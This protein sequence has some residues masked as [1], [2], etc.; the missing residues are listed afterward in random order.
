MK[1]LYIYSGKRKGRFNGR[2]GIDYPDTQFYGLNHLSKF[3]IEAEYKETSNILRKIF[4][5]RIAHMFMF[6]SVSNYNV[7]FGSSL[8]YM[9]FWN[10]FFKRKTKYVLLNISL[11]RT[12]SAN[13]DRKLKK[14]FLMWFLKEL[15]RVVCLSST[16]KEHL[17]KEAPFLKNKTFFVPLGIDATYFKPVYEDRDNF[18][19]SV[20]RDN[21][22]DYKTVVEVARMMPEEKFHIVASE[23]NLKGIK[24]IP[25]N[26]EL[27]FDIS[28]N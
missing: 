19:L 21:G 12:I 9:L 5:F 4:G 15:D 28:F 22:R 26:V 20:G 2:I 6:F 24:N 13:K 3:D 25:N 23:R 1:V 16:Q 18:I 14:A 10:K 17:E 27:F 8:M 7:V 11:N